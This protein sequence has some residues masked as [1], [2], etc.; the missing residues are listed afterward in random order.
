MTNKYSIYLAHPISGLGYDEVFGYFDN[1]KKLLE[2]AGY[3]VLNPMTG[4]DYLRNE[5]E[6]KSH[7]YDLAPPSTNHAIVERDLWMIGQVDIVLLDLSGSK[8]VSIGCMMELAWA[9]MLR[10]HTVVVVDPEN[11]H[12]HAFVL[13][14]ADVVF[15]KIGDANLYLIK[16]VKG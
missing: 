16:L 3:T 13:D 11:P 5:V 8:K 4:K 6:F 14:T 12:Y 15:E 7:G 1:Q 9:H 10:K 2:S